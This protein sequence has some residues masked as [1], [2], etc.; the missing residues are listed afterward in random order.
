MRT[1]RGMAPWIMVI[2]AVSFVGWMVFEVGMDVSGQGTAGAADEVGRVNGRRIDLR[3]YLVAL[4]NAQQAQQN[5]PGGAGRT[6]EEQRALEDAVF[7]QLVQEALLRAEYERRGIRVSDAEVLQAMLNAPPQEVMQIPEFQT[8]GQFDLEK[9]RR[10]LQTQADPSFRLGLEARYR[11]EIPRLKLLERLTS[12]VYVSDTKLW[13]MYRDRHDSTVARLVTL[14]PQVVT[15]DT[16][17][18]VGDAEVERYYREHPDEFERPAEA[19]L[20]YIVVPR[21][22]DAADTAAALERARQLRAEI[23]AGTPFAEV[24][25]R[26]SADSVSRE[27]GGDLGEASRGD[28]VSAFEEAAFALRPGELSQPVLSPFGYH[29]IRLEARSGDTYHPYHILIPIELAGDHLDAVEARADSLDLLVADQDDPT[30]LDRVAADM[31]LTISQGTV[32]EGDGL[33]VGRLFLTDPAIWAFDAAPGQT[34][35]V[36]ETDESYWVFRLDSLRPAGIPPLAAVR[37]LAAQRAGLAKQWDATRRL[38][39]AI[40]ADVA[41]GTPLAQAAA[42]RGLRA[43]ETETFTR[44]VPTPPL[45]DAPEALGAAFGTP[46]DHIAGPIESENAI[47]F[48]QPLRRFAADSADFVARIDSLRVEAVQRARQARVQLV[49]SSLREGASVEDR[50]RELQRAQQNLPDTPFPQNPFGF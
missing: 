13:R 12:D 35:P 6:L 15:R 49:L 30:L 3:S 8:E 39:Q 26:E 19:F 34:S 33:R 37:A 36:I 11:D 22:P 14:V 18:E 17:L 27:A 43:V 2:V 16:D 10:F 1:M 24:A 48:V 46:L 44:S 31:G 41:S 4:Q 5:Q 7:E 32:L 9:Y 25:A 38:A 23:A 45:R 40:A 20:S 21:V 47:F 50:R 42:A 28:F 29:L